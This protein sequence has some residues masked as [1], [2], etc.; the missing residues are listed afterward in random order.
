MIRI[1]AGTAD[2]IYNLGAQSHVAVTLRTRN[3]PPTVMRWARCGSWRR[4]GSL[5][6]K[7]RIYQASTSGSTAW[8]RRFRKKYA[9]LSPQPLRGSE[10]LCLLDLVNYRESYGMYA[11]NGVLFNHEN[12]G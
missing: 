1:I 9:L 6:D 2:E 12:G 5:A 8:C 7:T 10:A 4:C 3:T 11:C